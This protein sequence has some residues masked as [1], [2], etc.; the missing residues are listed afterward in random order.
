MS[1]MYCHSQFFILMRYK[2]VFGAT[3]WTVPTYPLGYL[4]WLTLT[5]I[6]FVPLIQPIQF[7]PNTIAEY[8]KHMY[9]IISY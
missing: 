8:T 7:F 5:F 4:F 3:F 9:G 6:F 1:A 2:V